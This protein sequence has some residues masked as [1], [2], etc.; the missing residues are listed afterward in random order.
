MRTCPSNPLLRPSVRAF[1]LFEMLALIAIIAIMAGVAIPAVKSIKDARSQTGLNEIR[2]TLRMMR[3]RAMVEGRPHA[4]VVDVSSGSTILTLKALPRTFP[5][6]TGWEDVPVP[7]GG[8]G[9]SIDLTAR[10]GIIISSIIDPAQSGQTMYICF[11]PDGSLR[12]RSPTTGE[13][14]DSYETEGRVLTVALEIKQPDAPDITISGSTG[15]V[16]N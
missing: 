13:V 4:V 1:T 8:A 14:D 3:T 10:Y 11:D 6:V 16:E 7:G 12:R 9:S 2:S 5:A 15:F